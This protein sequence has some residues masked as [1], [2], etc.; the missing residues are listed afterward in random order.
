MHWN[1]M[2]VGREFFYLKNLIFFRNALTPTAVSAV[3]WVASFNKC[4]K[5]F[6]SRPHRCCVTPYCVILLVA[7][8]HYGRRVAD[9]IL[10]WTRASASC[11]RQELDDHFYEVTVD[12]R[13]RYCHLSWPTTS[14]IMQFIALTACTFLELSW[15]HVAT[16]D[17]LEVPLFCRC[18]NLLITL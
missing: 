18:Q 2:Y 8:Y 3:T 17:V 1:T 11:C 15:Q 16:I 7:S 4:P 14:T 10:R 9:T 13:R 5:W 12:D 6:G